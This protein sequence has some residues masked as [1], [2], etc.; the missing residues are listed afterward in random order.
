MHLDENVGIKDGYTKQPGRSRRLR[1]FSRGALSLSAV[2][3]APRAV[4]SKVCSQRAESQVQLGQSCRCCKVVS[5]AWEIAA[6]PID[7]DER[8][9]EVGTTLLLII[10]NVHPLGLHT[11][12]VCEKG[13]G[14]C[15]CEYID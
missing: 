11:G 4:L 13:D 1:V 9:Q 7:R 15:S 2:A 6:G 14:S 3:A 12:F 5:G 10:Y 8:Q